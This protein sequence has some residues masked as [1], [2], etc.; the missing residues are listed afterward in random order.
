[1]SLSVVKF[2]SYAKS[3]AE[4][5]D[6]LAASKMLAGKK[7]I[8]I[9][10]NLICNAMPPVTTPARCCEAIVE[11][12]RACSAAKIIIAEGCG[13]PANE[14][15]ELFDVLGYT[16]MAAKLGIELVD[17]NTAPLKRLRNKSATVFP[18][19]YLPEILFEC[20]LISVPVLKAHSISTITGSM[21][22]MLGC[23]PPSHYGRGGHWKK[24]AFHAHMHRSIVELNRYRSPDL[25]VMDATVGLAEFHL[26]GR[27]CNPAV[28]KIIAGYSAL[29]VD[30]KA[31]DFLGLSWK[32]IG[33]L[34]GR[35]MPD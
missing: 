1:M 16:K 32:S 14:T 35:F 17:L 29:E 8:V 15:T 5:L 13:D 22:N 19:M 12:I 31:A 20:F 24:A 7:T 18:E 34:S 10:P 30:R 33:H 2:K 11:Y 28:K 9:K 26:G 4:A 3:V 25:S 27:R 23:A 6:G 21:K